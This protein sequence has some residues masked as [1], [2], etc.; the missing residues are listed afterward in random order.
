VK[1]LKEKLVG[2]ETKYREKAAVVRIHHEANKLLT[3]QEAETKAESEVYR[4][5]LLRLAPDFGI[6]G[7]PEQMIAGL[8]EAYPV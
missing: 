8:I 2:S 6:E 1:K 5:L 7:E 3:A 4:A